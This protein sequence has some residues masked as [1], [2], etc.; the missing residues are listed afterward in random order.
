MPLFYR[1]HLRQTP[2][3][4]S[5]LPP[6]VTSERFRRPNHSPQ[7]RHFPNTGLGPRTIHTDPEIGSQHLSQRANFLPETPFLHRTV[8]RAA[9]SSPQPSQ[10]T[11]VVLWPEDARRG[12]VG[13]S[14][15][16]VESTM[17]W[18]LY[19]RVFEHGRARAWLS[20]QHNLRLAPNT[21][22]AYGRSLEDYLAFCEREGREP[23]SAGRDHLALYVGDLSS[24][25]N[26]RGEKVLNIG[27]GAGLSNATIQ[28]RLTAVRLF[29]DHLV[30]QGL[31]RD[32]P[33]GRGRYT[34]GKAF[35]G[36][37]E[38][39]LLRRYRRLPWVP[40]DDEW[41][42][43]L[44]AAREEPLRNRLMLL[45]CYDGALR[46]EELVSLQVGDLDFPYRQ[47][48]VRAE[49]AKNGA[50]RVVSF[51]TT[52]AKLLAAY[53]RHRRR[54]SA[55]AGA[56]FLSASS[57]NRGEPLSAGMWNKAVRRIAERAGSPRFTPHTC[58]HLR[59]THMARAGL[60]IH[61]IALYAGHKS[62]Q[63]AT[64]YVHLSGAE[65]AEKVVRTMA[66]FDRMASEAL[67]SEA[68]E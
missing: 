17:R 20:M 46:R 35:A 7:R 10:R 24:R 3:G 14:V 30:E 25:P 2:V 18:E 53:Q 56:L 36:K 66:G 63:S 21:V 28:L 32:N 29:Y 48:R 40:G 5:H 45:L 1:G 4:E 52:T 62:I 65:V 55:E 41:K 47:A 8:L 60:D 54:L 37:R 64:L 50:G 23:E 26:P 16:Y 13:L 15:C 44:E 38:R 19:S 27:S 33:V 51:S 61:E 59:L 11:S 6:P 42:R 9:A 31:R 68:F 43:I 39:G 12:A 49:S 67:G 58:R 22:E 57:R 34:P